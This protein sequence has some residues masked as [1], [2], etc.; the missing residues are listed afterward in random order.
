M[1]YTKDRYI[2]NTRLIADL[3]Q[4]QRG[5]APFYIQNGHPAH[6]GHQPA[7]GI[8]LT[9][10]LPEAC[11]VALQ[12]SPSSEAWSLRPY[13]VRPQGCV[14]SE[15]SW[16]LVGASVSC[17]RHAFEPSDLRDIL[18][19]TRFMSFASLV[20]DLVKSSD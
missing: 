5:L 6:V 16:S 2:V 8:R 17:S 20:I 3:L 19:V 15:A 9:C 13:A 11:A 18:T 7:R 10:F 14:R 1:L 4:G 12:L